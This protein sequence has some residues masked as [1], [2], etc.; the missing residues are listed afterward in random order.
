MY[1]KCLGVHNCRSI[2]DAEI[3]LCPALTILV[4]EN[5]GSKRNTSDAI[6]LLTAP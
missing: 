5:N 2:S 6:R 3:S 4:G 1:L